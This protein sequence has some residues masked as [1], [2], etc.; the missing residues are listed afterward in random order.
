MFFSDLFLQK[1][2]TDEIKENKSNKCWTNF[3]EF[4]YFYFRDRT[5][6]R[7]KYGGVWGRESTGMYNL[8]KN[9]KIFKI[10]LAYKAGRPYMS[11]LLQQAPYKCE[12]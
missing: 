2:H 10:R 9:M 4:S 3:C 1:K 8:Y 6:A 12:I 11:V 5:G 7:R